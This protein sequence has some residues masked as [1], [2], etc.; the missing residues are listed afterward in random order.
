MAILGVYRHLHV[1]LNLDCVKA[2]LLL[3]ILNLK[4]K[5]SAKNT[6]DNITQ[7]K[8]RLRLHVVNA[9]ISVVSPAHFLFNRKLNKSFVWLSIFFKKQTKG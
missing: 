8:E 2:V 3:L 1:H 7:S 6:C 5:L 4:F 9:R